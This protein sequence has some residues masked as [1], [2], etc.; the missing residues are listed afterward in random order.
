MVGHAV[1]VILERMLIQTAS[2]LWVAAFLATPCSK[3]GRATCA[4]PNR[5]A[6]TAQTQVYRPKKARRHFISVSYE[7]QYVQPYSFRTHPLEDLLGQPVDEVHLQSFH[8]QTRDKQTLVTVNEFGNHGQAIG[9]TI[10]PFGSSEGP[11]LALR[12]SISSLPD[13]HVTFTGPAP[14][15]TYDLTNGRAYDIGAGLDMSDRAPGWGLGS[16]AFVIG[17]IGQ[18]STDQL[19]GK[20]WFVEGGGGVTSGP[21]GVDISFTYTV[22]TFDAPVSHS[23]RMIP[24]AV[25]GTLT[26]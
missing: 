18:V 21:L 14:S 15:P 2:A 24:I 16:H 4:E 1:Y 26:F 5:V 20:R 12:G 13:I 9:A 23:V 22:N 25:R 19:D 3:P 7:Q 8:Y 11:T 17:G 10:Y 6:E